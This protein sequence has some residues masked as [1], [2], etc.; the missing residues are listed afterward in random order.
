M[1]NHVAVRTD[2]GPLRVTHTC[3][4]YAQEL[5]SLEVLEEAI[6]AAA[7]EADF[8]FPDDASSSN[9]DQSMVID[10]IIESLESDALEAEQEA[11]LVRRAEE[12]AQVCL[13][14]TAYIL[15]FAVDEEKTPSEPTLTCQVNLKGLEYVFYANCDVMLT[16]IQLYGTLSCLMWSSPAFRL[17]ILTSELGF[18]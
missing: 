2:E 12:A 6:Q 15:S 9:G 8:T 4:A 7:L 13:L 11:L 14:D 5:A 1:P 16:I 10:D 18:I 3:H 17:P